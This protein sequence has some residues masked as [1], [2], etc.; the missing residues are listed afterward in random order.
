MSQKKKTSLLT[1]LGPRLYQS[2]QKDMSSRMLNREW[3]VLEEAD[4]DPMEAQPPLEFVSLNLLE[5]ILL[6]YHSY[7]TPILNHKDGAGIVLNPR[8]IPRI[9][10]E[11]AEVPLI[12]RTFESKS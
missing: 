8:S 10:V 5:D 4:E 9:R 7:M 11:R 1:Y 2:S 3:L 12:E 6:C